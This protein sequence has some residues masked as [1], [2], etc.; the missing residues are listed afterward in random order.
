MANSQIFQSI[1]G[2]MLPHANSFNE[3]AAPAYEFNERHLLAQYAVTGC[4]NATFYA[5]AVSQL[6]TLLEAC[7]NVEPRFIAK[8]A[9]YCRE[10]GYMKDTPALLTA[11][12]T[13][14]GPEYLPT[15]FARVIGNGKM[16][17]NVVQ[18]L[19]SGAIGR[20]SLG[21]RPKKLI[22][23]WL[24]TTSE[25]QLLN[26]AIGTQPSLADVIKMVHPKPNEVWREAF[27]A[28]V[29]GKP[30][31]L[32]NLPPLTK[33]Y[34]MYKRD[35]SQAVPEVPFQ[36]LTAL[37]LDTA[38]WT[39]IA[40]NAGWQ[41]LRMNL[42][43]FARHG[44]FADSQVVAALAEK[45]RNPQAI[46]KAKVFP[47]QLLA[48]YKASAQGIPPEL[49]EA[50]QDAMEIAL[51]NVPDMAGKVVVCPDVSGSM[52]SP[53]TGGRGSATTAVRCINVVAL[54]AAALLRKNPQTLVLP[55][56]NDV[57]NVDLNPRD[58]VM[59]NAQKLAAIG[60]GGTNCSA[61]LRRLNRNKATAD[62]V[63]LVSDNESWLDAKR[64]GATAMMDEWA[65]FKKRNPKAKLVCVDIQ[66]NRTTQAA[67]RQ[68]ILNVGGFSDAVFSVIAAF[69]A[70]QLQPEHWVGVIEETVL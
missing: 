35:T 21:T 13:L 7:Q 10:R 45:L 20:K 24:N 63:I 57:V 43:T 70:D 28:W 65:L 32:E 46:A 9:V 8:T 58:T 56:E 29:I 31:D 19:R 37:P 64:H 3:Q 15:V 42:N 22:Q 54:M 51:A 52:S 40:L 47:Y 38:Q 25:Q 62:L 33:A 48:A 59:T 23:N 30:Y 44:V 36:L 61:P 1:R 27:F 66:P 17:R 4:L 16:L 5:D 18:I 55:F 6:E 50:L 26:A 41:M 49:R 12:L 14:R 69:A 39:R 53:V 11:I 60:G 67:E 2:C 68:D 34:E